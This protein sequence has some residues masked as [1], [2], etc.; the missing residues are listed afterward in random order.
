[1]KTSEIIEFEKEDPATPDIYW[2]SAA[3]T[4]EK[5]DR[6]PH[7]KFVFVRDG[8]FTASDG[9][10]LHV[11]HSVLN[12]KDGFYSVIKRIKTNVILKFEGNEDIGKYPEYESRL[13]STEG[14]NEPF[15]ALAETGNCSV[16]YA[17]IVR[18][19][20][21]GTLNYIFLADLFVTGDHFDI[22]IKD[23]ESPIIFKH[24]SK[25]AVIMPMRE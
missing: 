8:V 19:M 4:K 6:R 10:R 16:P 22:F 13:I 5:Q 1:M 20:K 9:L 24:G 12:C 15:L 2:V 17:Q 11:Y 21:S 25:T 3:L 14:Y 7:V 18:A 23:A